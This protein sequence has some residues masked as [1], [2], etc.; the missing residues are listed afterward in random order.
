[1]TFCASSHRVLHPY[2]ASCCSH[3]SLPFSCIIASVSSQLHAPPTGL[4]LG[5]AITEKPSVF[6]HPLSSPPR[7]PPAAAIPAVTAGWQPN[8]AFFSSFFST[9]T[10]CPLW[11]HRRERVCVPNG[12]REHQPPAVFLYNSLAPAN[13]NTHKGGKEGEWI[14]EGGR[15]RRE[16][17]RKGKK[18]REQRKIEDLTQT[19]G[20]GGSNI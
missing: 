8:H 12:W 7:W 4:S 11:L 9:Q 5:S 18:W 20:G 13:T 2:W 15:V 6:H 19:G 10:H 1:M 17:A 16:T 3:L 14:R